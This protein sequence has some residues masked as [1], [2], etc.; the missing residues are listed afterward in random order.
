MCQFSMYC[1][2]P[3]WLRICT[4]KN[5]EELSL[6][7]NYL[8]VICRRNNNWDCWKWQQCTHKWTLRY[9][10]QNWWKCILN[11]EVLIKYV[12]KKHILLYKN[13]NYNLCIYTDYLLYT[14]SGV[15]QGTA[16]GPDILLVYVHNQRA[17]TFYFLKVCLAL[18]TAYCFLSD[19]R[20]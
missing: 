1:K 14:A 2:H 20:Y 9:T 18:H 19:V 7:K 6:K 4:L 11:L 3:Y 17:L 10:Y 13:L 15:L 16:L 5:L 12:T 8:R